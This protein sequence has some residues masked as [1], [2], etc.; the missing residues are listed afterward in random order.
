M[1]DWRP[2]PSR[3]Q[4]LPPSARWYGTPVAPPRRLPRWL[5][6]VLLGALAL[7]TA[8]MVVTLVVVAVLSRPDAPVETEQVDDGLAGI[9]FPLPRGWQRGVLAPVTGFTSVAANRDLATAMARPGDPV[10]PSA[11]RPALVDLT[12][13]Y[14]RL[15]LHGDK[16]DVVED[17]AV[18]IGGRAG[19]TRALRA[20]YT[21]VVNQPAFLRV[22]LLTAPSGGSVVVLGLAH[23][24]DPRSRADIDSIMAGVR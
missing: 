10:D 8:G 18:T 3:D 22:T 11:L 17:K 20:E 6:H 4:D 9:S 13:L 16:L 12:D 24:D 1:D 5:T 2:G 15:L 19:H 23:P 21:D 14:A 7:L